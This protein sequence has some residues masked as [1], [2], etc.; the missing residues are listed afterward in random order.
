MGLTSAID[1]QTD[2]RTDCLVANLAFQYVAR[3]K[4]ILRYTTPLAVS[5]VRS[6]VAIVWASVYLELITNF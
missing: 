1:R 2:G 3:P 6:Y 4:T 5:H